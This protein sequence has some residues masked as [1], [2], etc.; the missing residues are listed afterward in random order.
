MSDKKHFTR[1]KQNSRDLSKATP[2]YKRML[3]HCLGNHNSLT[4][5]NLTKPLNVVQLSKILKV[6]YRTAM[7]WKNCD[8]LENLQKVEAEDEQYN[9]ES[10]TVEELKNL[11]TS[12]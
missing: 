3:I 1:E 5:N 8:L 7:M 4:Q 9:E 10:V 12:K 11:N 2:E 6:N